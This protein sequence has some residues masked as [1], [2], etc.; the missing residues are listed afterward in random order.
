MRGTSPWARSESSAV[1]SGG[2]DAGGVQEHQPPDAGRP[3]EGEPCRDG[4]AQRVAH[5]VDGAARH[6]VQKRADLEGEPR[7]VVRD[8]RVADG[9]AVAGQVGREQA[10]AVGVG[11]GEPEPGVFR[12]PE[13]VDQHD[14][15]LGAGSFEVGDRPAVDLDGPGL[16]AGVAAPFVDADLDDGLLDG[17]AAREGGQR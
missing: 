13:P 11:L 14:R 9:P 10:P 4:P 16:E 1:G 12:G 8:G 2:A 15:R 3:L 17:G 6:R 5:G 7:G